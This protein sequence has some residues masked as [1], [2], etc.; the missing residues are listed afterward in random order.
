MHKAMLF[1]LYLPKNITDCYK[2]SLK[3]TSMEKHL[4]PSSKSLRGFIPRL[5]DNDA[6]REMV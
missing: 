5:P 4:L 1:I 2:T 6:S 3:K